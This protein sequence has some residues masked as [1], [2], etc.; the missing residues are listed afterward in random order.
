MDY[1]AIVSDS[2]G[3][4]RAAL[5][6]NWVTWLIFILCSL[7]I[8]L[9]RF[10]CDPTKII[11]GTTIH[12]EL[13]PWPQLIVLCLAGLLLSFITSGYLVRVY[14]GT[15]PPPVFD[16]WGTLFLDGI[17]LV[18]VGILWFVPTMIIFAAGFALTFF[19]T[20]TG[21]ASMG[22]MLGAGVLLFLIG[23][24]LLV[25]AILYGILG[26]VRFARTGSI[27]GGIRFSAIT[28][29]IQA[30]GWGTYILALVILVVLALLFSVV[31]SLLALIPLVGWVIQLILNPLISIFSARFICRVYDHSIPQAPSPEPAPVV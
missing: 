29:T 23:L 27:R 16:A 12:W 17:K 25:I 19:G 22:P 2:I 21:S 13:I 26:S 3:Y 4:T 24:I 6:G 9:I 30:I 28:D 1:G 20:H 7:P 15:T 11:T 8:A 10:V 5:V 14:R 31:V 18:V